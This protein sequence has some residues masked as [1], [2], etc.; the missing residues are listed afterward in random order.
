MATPV[1]SGTAA[2]IRQYFVDG[3]YPD[4]VKD[5]TKSPVVEKPSGA[6][7]KAVLMNSGQWLQGVDN[8]NKGVTPIKPYDNTQNFGRVS[9][10]DAVYLPGRTNMQ[11]TAFDR[12]VVFDQDSQTYAVTIDKSDGCTYDKLAVTLVWTE[13]GSQPGCMRCVLNDLD[14]RVDVDGKTYYPNGRSVPDRHNNAE[15]VVITGI[16]DGATADITV[17]GYNLV[18]RKQY[19]AI[20]ATG[21]FGGVANMNF[22]DQCSVFECDDSEKKRR[23]AIIMGITIPI[24]VMLLV[25]GAAFYRKR[26]KEQAI[27]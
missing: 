5:D 16:P 17:E 12:Q 21:C 26:K 1:V 10:Q 11:L 15:R 19:Y 25:S 13:P 6:L 24:G 8:G 18:K 23:N 9:M 22:E 3:Y 2:I 20:V 14:L 7:I 27:A 4:G